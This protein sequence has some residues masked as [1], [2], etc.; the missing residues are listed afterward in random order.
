MKRWWIW[1]SLVLVAGVVVIVLLPGES[2][3]KQKVVPGQKKRMARKRY[4]EYP[5]CRICGYH[6]LDSV[7]NTCLNCENS[8]S[9]EKAR[10]EGVETIKD[11]II[12]YQLEYFMPEKEGDLIDFYQPEYAQNVYPKD[13]RWSP[14][15][16][17]SE[18]LDFFRIVNG[19]DSILADSLAN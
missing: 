6:A 12:L 19:V 9:L 13:E 15:V 17:Q 5:G 14:S 10:E 2:K 8:V 4:S 3:V 11:L 18:V 1:L 7:T 16:Y